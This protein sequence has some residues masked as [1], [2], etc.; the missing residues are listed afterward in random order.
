VR[1]RSRKSG[2]SVSG[3]VNMDGGVA[4]CVFFSVLI[5]SFSLSLIHSGCDRLRYMGDVDM[6]RRKNDSN[7]CVGKSSTWSHAVGVPMDLTQIIM[8]TFRLTFPPPNTNCFR[9]ARDH[10]LVILFT[11]GVAYK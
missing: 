1:G 11:V 7:F 9:S 5:L 8:L 4:Y 2:V 10:P 3:W 6:E